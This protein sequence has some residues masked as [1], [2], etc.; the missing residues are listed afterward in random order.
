MKKPYPPQPR[1]EGARDAPDGILEVSQFFSGSD[2]S[3][4][5]SS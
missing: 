2:D 3:D 4:A 1:L 5:R